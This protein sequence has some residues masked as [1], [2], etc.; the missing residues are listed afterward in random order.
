MPKGKKFSKSL[1]RNVFRKVN[2]F[3]SNDPL[4]WR[5]DCMD[6]I[7]S[8][9]NYG[10]DVKYGWNICHLDNDS[11]NNNV[12]NLMPQSYKCYK[13]CTKNEKETLC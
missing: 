7:I 4:I 2:I 5:K 1:R 9:A 8:L 3:E 10:K 13:I 12:S 11:N 6:E